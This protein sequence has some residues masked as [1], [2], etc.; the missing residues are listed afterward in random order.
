MTTRICPACGAQYLGWVNRCADCGVGLTDSGPSVLDL[1]DDDQ[2]VYELIEWTPERRKILSSLL[3]DE[4]VGF[5]WEGTDLIVHVDDEARVDDMVEAIEA[6]EPGALAAAKSAEDVGLSGDQLVY[7]LS[8]W[9]EG[10]RAL[11]TERLH[12]HGIAYLWDDA[13]NLAVPAAAEDEVEAILDAVEDGELTDP[14]AA[15]DDEGSDAAGEAM[16]ELFLAADR[17]QH[18]PAGV[19]ALAGFMVAADDAAEAG[20]PYGLEP[21]VWKAVL[22]QSDAVQDLVA[23]EVIDEDAIAEGAA[24]LRGLLRPYV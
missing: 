2:L 22:E 16:S 17:L 24:T 19:D 7:D 3:Q 11:V 13:A 23:A 1:P 12:A 14:Q 5:A 18:D 8:E 10:E 15:T 6:V 9:D 20:T 4:G 21:K